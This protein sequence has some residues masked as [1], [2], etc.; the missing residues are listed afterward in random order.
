MHRRP[1]RSTRTHT[2]LPYTTLLL[3]TFQVPRVFQHM[4]L[5][6]NMDV[7]QVASQAS[8]AER[9]EQSAYWLD[10]VGLLALRSEEHTSELQSSMRISYAGLCMKKKRYATI[11]KQTN[12]GSNK[13]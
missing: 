6:D 12:I 4:T 3:S 10:K 8:D 7:A 1:P 11:N 2:L 13:V 9:N 5:L